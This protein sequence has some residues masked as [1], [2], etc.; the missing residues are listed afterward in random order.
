MELKDVV[1]LA[2]AAFG[3]IFLMKLGFTLDVSGLVWA[4]RRPPFFRALAAALVTSVACLMLGLLSGPAAL[5]SW[6]LYV[7]LFHYASLFCLEDVL[8]QSLAFY[9]V[10]AAP[11]SGWS[12]DAALGVPAPWGRLPLAP[13]LALTV[14]SG[15]ILFSAGFEK[16]K[17]PL[18]RRGMG[19]YYFFLLPNVRR[20]DT[21]FITSRRWLSVLMNHLTFVFEMGYL[22]ALL[23]AYR[24]LGAAAWLLAFVFTFSLVVAFVVHWIGEAQLIMLGIA[25]WLIFHGNVSLAADWA[26][27]LKMDGPL[28][29]ALA[30]SL[31]PCAWSVIIPASA[32]FGLPHRF[33]RTLSRYTWGLMPV[34]AFNEM[35]LK[36]PV[37]Y[38]VL[39]SGTRAAAWPI[40]TPE[41]TPGPERSF[42]PTFFETMAYKV[43]EICMELDAYGEVRTPQRL[44]FIRGLAELARRKAKRRL[45][46]LPE[47][48]L[49]RITQINPPAEF[50]GASHW[51][52]NDWRVDAFEI[53][54]DA[55]GRALA[56]RV[57]SKPIL[58]YETGRDLK[59]MS[60]RFNA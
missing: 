28:G 25:V 47:S 17:S 1:G 5:A 19:C 13:E 18:W 12:I 31:A 57:L 34:S 46:R 39:E 33:L 40:F 38:E 44:D 21:S 50:V 55:E 22:P 56:P 2:R 43:T 41:C 16:A 10:F 59:R 30:L 6:L 58:K 54:F 24:P 35:H 3:A 37:V 51:Y 45:G 8:F 27:E 7:L 29:W 26:A 20:L 48:L 11:G 49:F 52:L 23:L 32:P 15:L 14:V 36:G 42:R 60:L 4:S 53:S 9:F